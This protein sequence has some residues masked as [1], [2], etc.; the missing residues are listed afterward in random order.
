LSVPEVQIPPAARSRIPAWVMKVAITAS[1]IW[2]FVWASLG[3]AGALRL[4]LEGWPAI[5]A[6]MGTGLGLSWAKDV[7]HR[8]ID[9]KTG[10]C[11]PQEEKP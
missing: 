2:S 3:H 4:W 10:A 8:N 7:A 6:Y 1:V 9:A 5:L 11:K